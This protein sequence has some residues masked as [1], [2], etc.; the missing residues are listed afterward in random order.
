[1]SDLAL[2]PVPG[3]AIG[4]RAANLGPA[5]AAENTMVSW[6]ERRTGLPGS[7]P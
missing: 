5:Q 3:D 1:M 7:T 2:I 6:P 4:P